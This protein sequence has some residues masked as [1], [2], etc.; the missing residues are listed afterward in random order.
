MDTIHKKFKK[1]PLFF[2]QRAKGEGRKTLRPS[3]LLSNNFLCNLSLPAC[4]FAGALLLLF[5]QAALQ[6]ALD[7]LQGVVDGFFVAADGLGD[8]LV[9][10]ARKVKRKH[11]PL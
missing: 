7:A 1:T 2:R 3:P 9:A 11:L 6:L 4:L 5:E 10:F 8:L